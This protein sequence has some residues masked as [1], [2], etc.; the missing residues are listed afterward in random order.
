[1]RISQPSIIGGIMATTGWFVILLAV[2]AATLDAQNALP[3]NSVESDSQ[4]FHGR[5]VLYKWSD[6]E[7]TFFDDFVV[8]T[9]DKITPFVRVIYRPLWGFDAPEPNANDRL[10]RYAFLAHGALWSFSVR[11]PGG[12]LEKSACE[13]VVTMVHYQDET[14][15]GDLPVYV[16]TPGASIPGSFDIRRIPCFILNFGGMKRVD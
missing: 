13:N 7:Y 16:P 2:F 14:G 9:G 6:H 5:I 8:K 10:D 15:S 3:A 4:I 12:E 11:N 1:M